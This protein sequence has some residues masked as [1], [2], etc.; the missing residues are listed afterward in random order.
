MNTEGASPAPAEGTLVLR[1][2]DTTA[3]GSTDEFLKS[4][5]SFRVDEYG[6][7]VCFVT[8]GTDEVGV[9]MGWEKPISASWPFGLF[10]LTFVNGYAPV[11]ETVKLLRVQGSSTDFRV[12]NCGFGLGIVSE[13][14]PTGPVALVLSSVDRI[15]RSM[16]SFKPIAMVRQRSM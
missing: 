9:M 13:S 8:S 10:G 5:L 15:D 4:K 3:A 2:A 12:L 16:R 7:E 14:P 11:E 6:Q 1:I